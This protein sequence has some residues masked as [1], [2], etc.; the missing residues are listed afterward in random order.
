MKRYQKTA[1]FLMLSAAIVSASACAK[2]PAETA[3]PSTTASTM[4]PLETQK[5]TQKETESTKETLEVKGSE[6]ETT[7]AVQSTTASKNTS[8]V[9]DL[10]SKVQK[11]VADQDLEALADLVAYPIGIASPDGEGIEVANKEEFLKLKPEDV[12]TERLMN[13]IK[14]IKASEVEIDKDDL[15]VMGKGTINI[16]LGMTEEGNLRVVAISR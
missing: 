2:K 3:A 12:F 16:A 7:K 8:N 4:A 1:A 15:A 9:H 10:A 5:E 13:V 6:A 14:G 11:A